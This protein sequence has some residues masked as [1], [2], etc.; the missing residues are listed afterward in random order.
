MA[1]Q[2]L[3]ADAAGRCH[4]PNWC[5]RDETAT[6]DC[7]N[8]MH[9]AVPGSWIWSDTFEGQYCSGT[10]SDRYMGNPEQCTRMRFMCE[11]GESHFSNS[12]GCGCRGE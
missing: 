11:P 6:T 12:C 7:S 8:L 3:I 10:P 4:T 5:G 2:W 9:I 1:E